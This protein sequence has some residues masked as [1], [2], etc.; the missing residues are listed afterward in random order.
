MMNQTDRQRAFVGLCL[1]ILVT[2]C[3]DDP[4]DGGGTGA[5]TATEGSSGTGGATP[6]G[7]QTQPSGDTTGDSTTAAATGTTASN[8]TGGS[9]SSGAGSTDESG[10]TG[11]SGTTGGSTDGSSDS[12]S[13]DGSGSTGEEDCV[14][15]DLGMA[16]GVD[17]AAGT[18]VGAGDDFDWG[19][20]FGKPG[21]FTNGPGDDYVLSWTPPATGPYVISLEGAYDTFL[22]V[23]APACDGAA[24]TCND[25][26]NGLLSGMVYEATMG[27]TVFIVVDGF[28]GDVGNFSLSI[29]ASNDPMCDGGGA[30]TGDGCGGGWGG[31]GDGS[32]CSMLSECD[33]VVREIDCDDVT[34][35]CVEDAV[36]TG[37]CAAGD[38]CL[39]LAGPM[40]E[41]LLTEFG[42][43]CCGWDDFLAGI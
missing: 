35:T 33:G 13:T 34:C 12:G 11:D 25:D 4:A 27:Q 15:E 39:D 22:T 26:C 36:I 42:S 21:G 9:T 31:A 40:P 18:T 24:E 29:E 5:Q 10:T 20:C 23:A 43:A 16:V 7:P 1:T 38:I 14:D 19:D 17:I 32:S 8:T 3:P 2:G 37:Q 6:S 28:D 41:A 30:T